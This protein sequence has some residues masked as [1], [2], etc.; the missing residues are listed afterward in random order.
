[1]NYRHILAAGAVACLLPFA[2][3]A[4]TSDEITQQIS[5]LVGQLTALQAQLKDVTAQSVPASAPAISAPA[6]SPGR[7]GVV[8]P[9]FN[10]TLSRGMTGDAV[11]ALQKFLIGRGFLTAD[12]ATGFF[13]PITESAVRNLQAQQDIVSSGDAASTGWGVVG[14]RTSAA[15]VKLCSAAYT[16]QFT[17]TTSTNSSG[18]PTVPVPSSACNGTWTATPNPKG[19]VA[20]WQC[21]AGAQATTTVPASC[22]I[23]QMPTCS[24]GFSAQWR[25]NDS[26]NCSLG[27]QCVISQTT[28]S[29]SFSA[30]P[31]SG[32]A[33]LG[34][35]FR[36]N[37]QGT[38]VDFGD[39]TSA[40]VSSDCTTGLNGSINCN[41]SSYFT[42][43][44]YQSAGTYTASLKGIPINGGLSALY[45]RITIT[46]Q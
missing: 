30:S 28:T 40:L 25:G 10:L 32:R 29:A 1:M 38:Q 43:H 41:T 2:A 14:A 46:V 39:G 42:N 15:I 19:C 34:V 33:P 21:V 12:S 3:S 35:V 9:V 7:T 27:Y 13:G 31:T 44:Y 23:Y 17:S 16:A 26:N 36:T 24:V 37:K 6:A 4:L 45:G 18:C 8:C 20:A 11:M 22:P 5:E